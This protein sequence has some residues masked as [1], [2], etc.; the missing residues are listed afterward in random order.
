[1]WSGFFK[2]TTAT[3][4]YDVPSYQALPSLQEIQWYDNWKVK[5]IWDPSSAISIHN[6]QVHG[7]HYVVNEGNGQA[8]YIRIVADMTSIGYKH[9]W[10]LSL[11]TPAHFTES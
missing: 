1:M 4:L 7:V 9:W 8:T 2:H 11:S 5:S 10:L 6:T 3:G